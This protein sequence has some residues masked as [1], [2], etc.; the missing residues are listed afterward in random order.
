M[1][2]NRAAVG[3]LG[4][5]GWEE[6]DRGGIGFGF[7]LSGLGRGRLAEPGKE[8][9]TRGGKGEG[10]LAGERYTEMNTLIYT[11]GGTQV[12]GG[13]GIRFNPGTLRLVELH[14]RRAVCPNLLTSSPR[15]LASERLSSLSDYCTRIGDKRRGRER[16]NRSGGWTSLFLNFG[17]YWIFLAAE[18]PRG[19]HS[20]AYLFIWISFYSPKTCSWNNQRYGNCRCVVCVSVCEVDSV[21][22]SGV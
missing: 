17:S 10:A 8:G 5:D 6:A 16:K 2:T 1:E 11:A 22:C 14:Q 13:T 18:V 7:F 9:G 21:L 20:F 4:G 15:R 3:R 12:A 19:K